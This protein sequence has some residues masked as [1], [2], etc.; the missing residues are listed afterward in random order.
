MFLV[1]FCGLCGQCKSYPGAVQKISI[2]IAFTV[3]KDIYESMNSVYKYLLAAHEEI[4][5]SHKS[6]YKK[7]YKKGLRSKWKC[8]ERLHLAI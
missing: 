8:I 7:V 4:I 3:A 1:F 6:I 2:L 5:L